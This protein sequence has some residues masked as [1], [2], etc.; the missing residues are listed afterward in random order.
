MRSGRRGPRHA[1]RRS[2]L[3]PLLDASFRPLDRATFRLAES[4]A[5]ANYV[6]LATRPV[7]ES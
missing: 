2:R 1:Q 6:A 3:M 7:L 4:H 5:L